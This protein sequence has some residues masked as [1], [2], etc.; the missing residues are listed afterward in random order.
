MDTVEEKTIEATVVNGKTA[1]F[2]I[3]T[4]FTYLSV[5]ELLTKCVHVINGLKIYEYEHDIKTNEELNGKKER[6]EKLKPLVVY[7]GELFRRN[8]LD[9]TMTCNIS[10]INKN[11]TYFL[12]LYRNLFN[13]YCLSCKNKVGNDGYQIVNRI[14]VQDIEINEPY[15][16]YNCYNT[17][18]RCTV[19]L[20]GTIH[21]VI[22]SSP[23]FLPVQLRVT[24]SIEHITQKNKQ[25]L[26]IQ[27]IRIYNDLNR[28][29]EFV[30]RYCND[31]LQEIR[32]VKETMLM[33]MKTSLL[34][35]E[36]ETCMDEILDLNG[37]KISQL[38]DYLTEDQY[39]VVRS[40]A[41]FDEL[42]GQQDMLDR[43]NKMLMELKRCA[44]GEAVL[45]VPIAL[46][47]Q[48]LKK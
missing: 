30:Y 38:K 17:N 40:G 36:L 33:I 14:N 48:K 2:D 9:L 25:H 7:L 20:H 46:P 43:M 37:N 44:I 42:E 10:G 32:M 6:I 18:K 29:I 47:I 35:K 13:E 34:T 28:M 16:C 5:E 31:K 23:R 11:I 3:D 22:K 24:V 26:D 21:L 4:P 27:N 12:W 19:D 1:V 39:R 8:G 15:L 45:E 41:K